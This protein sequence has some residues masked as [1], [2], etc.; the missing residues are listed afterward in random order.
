MIK[1]NKEI[2]IY[3]VARALHISPSTVSRGLKDHPHIKKETRAK[4]QALAHEMGYQRNKFASS[5]RKKRTETIGVIVPKLNSYF[6]ATAIAGIEKITNEHGYGLLISQSQESAKQEAACI[7]TLYNSRVD[8][9]IISLAYDTK[10]LDHF[11]ILLN[12][13]IPVVFFDRVIECP[14]CMS[15]IIDNFKAGYEVTSHLIQQGCKRIVHL[16]GNLLRN[17]YMERFNGYKQALLDNRLKYDPDQLIISE[18]NHE[19]GI[20][21]AHTIMKM[22]SRP[23]G[24]FAANDATAVAAICELQ[25]LGLKVPDDV[26]VAG[27]NNEPVSQ[28]VQPNLT[29]IDYP[30]KD[31]GEIAATSLI[32]KLNNTGT[33]NLSTIVLN[34]KLIIRGSTLR[35][36]T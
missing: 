31:I 35:K 5:L 30:A 19:A 6:Q 9:L 7:S 24:I 33:V 21:A 14:G 34:H 29:T 23:D 12:K 8:G 36:K 11:N 26:A 1:S 22:K 27:F 10:K 20:N 13:N 2:T 25:K 3:D 18:L 17:V 15:V 32:N 4:I 16:G 28:V